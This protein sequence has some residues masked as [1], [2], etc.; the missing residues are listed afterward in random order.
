M[1]TPSFLLASSPSFGSGLP[2]WRK[3][4]PSANVDRKLDLVVREIKRYGI[5]V[6]GIQESRWFG[7][8]VWPAADGFTF[9]HSGRPLPKD[10]ED[11]RRNEG[12][13]ILLD[14]RATS[15]WKQG[16][17]V[18]EAVSSRVIMVRLKLLSK[19]HKSCHGL[20]T[21]S[22]CFLTVICVYAPTAKAPQG[23]KDK[24][25][26]ELQDVLDRVPP[27]DVLLVL[28]DLNARVGVLKPGDVTWRGMIGEYGVDER[29]EAGEDFLQFCTVNHLTVMNTW[30]QKKRVQYGTWMHPA[31]K[32][33]HTID[34][35]VMKMS[36]RMYCRDVQVMR[37]ASC[38]TDHKLVRARFSFQLY[39]EGM[40]R[41]KNAHT[42]ISSCIFTILRKWS[43]RMEKSKT[44]C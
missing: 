28:G 8:D 15:A 34:L 39:G 17:E 4:K 42:F 10:G 24:F 27:N 11:A 35:V 38:W 18:W 37:G 32:Q 19:G 3:V 13:G 7:S 6:A 25:S 40:R 5:S 1:P 26:C 16:G 29:N 2:E 36:Q 23:I 33:V 22:Q 30:F 14:G 20:R 9:L 31:T 43:T 21:S 12:V 44:I 41:E